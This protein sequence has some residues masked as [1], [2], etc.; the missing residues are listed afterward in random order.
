MVL[1]DEPLA[2]RENVILVLNYVVRWETATTT[3]QRHGTPGCMEPQANRLGCL[4]L[5]I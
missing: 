2:I 5:C 1:L 3:S 4:N